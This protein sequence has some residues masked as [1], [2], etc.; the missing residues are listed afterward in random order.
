MISI[1]NTFST[2]IN[3]IYL[4]LFLLLLVII[5]IKVAYY[6]RCDYSNLVTKMNE[7][8]LTEIGE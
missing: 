5:A 1:L 4:N 2:K 6:S 8:S 7:L 3:L